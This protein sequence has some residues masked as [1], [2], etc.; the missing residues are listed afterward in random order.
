[1]WFILGAVGVTGIY[2]VIGLMSGSYPA[3]YLSGLA[4]TVTL[5]GA[6]PVDAGNVGMR[7][8]LVAGQFVI[9][10]ALIICTGVVYDQL[11]YIRK[12]NLG[13]DMERLV[14]VPL[15]FIPVIEKARMYRQRARAGK[16]IRGGCHGYLYPAF[17][18]ERRDLR[19]CT[20]VER[21]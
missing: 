6:L 2:P 12:K 15:T 8:I 21:G 3:L 9:S 4:P 5:K 1:M 14:A 7:R 10:I 11:D 18:Q 16:S 17:P 19:G 13:M 20:Q